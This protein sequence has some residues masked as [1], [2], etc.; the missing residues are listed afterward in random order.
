MRDDSSYALTEYHHQRERRKN[1]DTHRYRGDESVAAA[2]VG[3][4]AVTLRTKRCQRRDADETTTNGA[5][6]QQNQTGAVTKT[7][8]M[9]MGVV[10]WNSFS[11]DSHHKY[12]ERMAMWTSM[13]LTADCSGTATMGYWVLNEKANLREND[14]VH[15]PA[16]TLS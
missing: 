11:R 10:L 5:M 3:H 16:E 1:E 2:E 4:D 12:R 9:L 8:V 15:D 7:G 14:W 13:R 6:E